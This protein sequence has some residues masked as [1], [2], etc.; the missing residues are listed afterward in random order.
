LTADGW[1]TRRE[2]VIPFGSRGCCI[3]ANTRPLERP[4]LYNVTLYPGM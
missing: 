3:Y 2:E 1:S 4:S